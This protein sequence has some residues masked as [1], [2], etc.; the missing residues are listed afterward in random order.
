LGLVI[1]AWALKS[2]N[3]KNRF[4]IVVDASA[5]ERIRGLEERALNLSGSPEREM[6]EEV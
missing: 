1:R 5:L 2:G 3:A 6:T 4:I